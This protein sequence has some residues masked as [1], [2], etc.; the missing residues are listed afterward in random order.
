MGKNRAA[1]QMQRRPILHCWNTYFV[2]NCVQIP[3]FPMLFVYPNLI[4]GFLCMQISYR[5][6]CFFIPQE[7]QFCNH[8]STHRCPAF[9]VFF[10]FFFQ[11]TQLFVAFA[12]TFVLFLRS[13]LFLVFMRNLMSIGSIINIVNNVYIFAFLFSFAKTWFF[14]L[15]FG[16]THM[17]RNW[18]RKHPRLEKVDQNRFKFIFESRTLTYSP[19][20][21]LDIF[22]ESFSQFFFYFYRNGRI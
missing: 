11:F 6:S 20:G 13:S 16:L 12:S 21:I 22:I 10:S 19:E 5:L 18:I 9:S 17:C 2:H 14:C 15:V 8:S 3:R 1:T 7:V 4:L